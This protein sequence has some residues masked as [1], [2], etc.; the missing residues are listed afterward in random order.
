MLANKFEELLIKP[1]FI[2]ALKEKG[3]IEPTPIQKKSIPKVLKGNDILGIAQTGSGKTAAFILQILQMLNNKQPQ[4]KFRK[5]RTL[6]LVP[7]R[8][9][10]IQIGENI[11]FYGKYVA[12]KKV[13][14]YGGVSQNPQVNSLK[15]GVDIIVATPGRLLDLINQG[16]CNL[17]NIQHLVL[18][19]SDRMLDMGFIKDIKK[20]TGQLPLHRQTLLF[21]ATMPDDVAKLAYKLLNNPENISIE[22]KS[23][24]VEQLSQFVLFI[25]SDKKKLYLK[26]LLED[27]KFNSVVVFTRT[28]HKADTISNFLK[29]NGIKA[30]ALHGRKSQNA[31]I[32]ILTNFKLSKLRVLVATDVA[33]RGI[34]VSGITHVINYEIPNVPE[35]YIH[36]IGRTARAGE[37]GTAISLCSPEEKAYLNNIEKLINCDI[38]NYDKL[39]NFQLINNKNDLKPKKVNKKSRNKKNKKR[40]IRKKT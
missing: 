27:S 24:H 40:T 7:T 39:N 18:D 22:S 30:D 25:D 3:Y 38:E 28:K 34:D 17:N 32:K 10:A 19:E 5:V 1:P 6:I 16:Y 23:I 4:K 11:N 9:L 37:S 15:K 14:I 26:N 2:R 8:E 33:S 31:R 29:K 36:R 21:T 35:D 12:F 13:I 20:I